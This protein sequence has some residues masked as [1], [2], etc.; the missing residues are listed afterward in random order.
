[1]D[2]IDGGPGIIRDAA[3]DDGD[4]DPLGVESRHQIADI[5]HH[6]DHQ[7]VG[8]AAGP[9]HGEG[10]LVAFGVGNV[11]ALVHRE[12]G[13]GGELAA[14]RADDQEFAWLSSVSLEKNGG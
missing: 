13:R 1:M 8:A 7:Q 6:V 5:E 9:K 2:G 12:L 14:E 3:G 11:G 4:M 10:L